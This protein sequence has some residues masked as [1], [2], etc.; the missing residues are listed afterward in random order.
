M[1]ANS[2][3]HLAGWLL[4]G[5][6]ATG[7]YS[8]TPGLPFTEDF[9]AANLRDN[10]LTSAHWNTVQEKL[11]LDA[12]KRQVSPFRG[13]TGQDLSTGTENNRSIVLG[14][15]D[16]DGDL[17]VVAGNYND[18]NRVYLNDGSGSFTVQDLSTDSNSTTSIVIGDLDRDG[19]LDV[20]AGNE[21]QINRIYLNDGAGS[22]TGQDLSTDTHDTQSLALGDMDGDGDL[23]LMEGN[24]GTSHKAN[25]WFR[26]DGAGNF[27]GGI[28][29][30]TIT[31]HSTRSI[32]LGD[33]DGDGDLDMITGNY[34][35]NN[36]LH[37]NSGNGS[38][39]AVLDL[40]PD[41]L[42]T[43][44]V[45]LG[46]IDNDGDLDLVTGN[47]G[48]RNR[49]YSND[50]SGNFTGYNIS[51]DSYQ[52]RSVT[53]A[54]IDED[55][56]LD[57]VAGNSNQ[58]NR[59]YLN[60]GG[61]FAGE[62]QSL[63]SSPTESVVV[64]DVDGDGHPDIIAGNNNQKIRLYLNNATTGFHAQDLSTDAMNSRTV[65]LGDLDGDSDLDIVVGNSNQTNRIYFNEGN[66][67]FSSQDLSPNTRSTFSIAL[68]DLD[69]DGSL[70]MV[71]GNTSLQKNFVYLNDGTGTFIS[72]ELSATLQSSRAIV[73]GDVDSDGDLDVVSGNHGSSN[74]LFLNNGDGS[75]SDPNVQIGGA[76]N[77][78]ALQLGDIDG[79]GDL[80][81]IAGNLGQVNI[82]YTN[83][84]NGNFSGQD[85]GAE[86]NDTRSIVLGDVDGDGDLDLVVGNANGQNNRLYLND[87]SGGFT[88]QNLGTGLNSTFSVA[89]G[90]VDND[91]DIDVTAAN[92]GGDMDRIYLNDG[93]GG[94]AGQDLGPDILS[95]R[96]VALGD[97]DADGDLDLVMVNDAELDRIYLN[98]NS[99]GFSSQPMNPAAMDTTSIT[100]GDLDADGD[101]DMVAAVLGGMNQIYRNDAGIF[102]RH[103]LHSNVFL[104]RSVA[105][106]DLD[107]DS[108]LDVVVGNDTEANYLYWNDGNGNYSSQV[109]TPTQHATRSIALGDL[110]GD[111]DLD[112]ATAN[113][114]QRNQLYLNDGGG[115]FSL[116]GQDLSTDSNQSYSVVLGDMNNDGHLDVVVGN[117]G[118]NRVYINDGSAGFTG[119]DLGTQTNATFSVRL[120]D[121]DQDGD[122][123][124]VT[125]NNSSPNMVHIN[126]GAGSFSSSALD[127]YTDITVSITLGDVD[128]DGDLDII[129]GN[130][131]EVNR[132]FL[133]DGTGSFTGQDLGTPA[134]DTRS[135][136]L[137]DMDRDGS[138]DLVT[139]NFGQEN[140]LYL[141]RRFSTVLNQAGSLR[142]DTET[143]NI[144]Q[145]LLSSSQLTPAN[146][147]VRYYLSNNGGSQWFLA[148]PGMPLLFPTAG[149]DLRWRAELHSLSPVHSPEVQELALAL[150]ALPH[151]SIG[152]T[153]SGLAAGNSVVL[154]NNGGDDLALGADAAF[155]FD[156]PLTDG[157]TY[158][159]TVLTQ[160]AGSQ[161][162]NVNNGNGT[163]SGADVT[164]ISITCVTTCF[165]DSHEPDDASG[166][167]TTIL[168]G[169]EQ[170]HSICPADDEDW[171][172]F[173]VAE[174]SKVIIGTS[175]SSTDP[176]TEMWLYDEALIELEYNDT[177]NGVDDWALIDR[178]CGVDALPAGTYYARIRDY[179]GNDEIPSYALN[180]STSACTGSAYYLLGGNVSGLVTGNNV[181][182]QNNGGDDLNITVNGAFTFTTPLADGSIYNASILSQPSHPDQTC[183]V[184]NGSGAISGADIS[185][186]AVTCVTD[187]LFD[188]VPPGY[189]AYDFIQT[190]AVSG[191]TSGCD[192]HNYCPSSAVSRAQMAVF[193]GRGIHGRYYIPPSATGT[194]FDDVPA[195]HWAAGWIEQLSADG[196]TGGC[197]AGNYCPEN[198]VSRDQMAV[199]L[200]RSKHGSA[201]IP[202]PASGTIFADVPASHWASAWIE[203]LASEGIS[204][205]CD[206]GNYCPGAAVQRDQ[207]A[208]FLVRTFAL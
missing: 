170:T 138:L 43:T 21:S 132:L 87:G 56:D 97:L 45:A 74:R 187:P 19:D 75:F 136:V 163:V 38:F 137:I 80:D 111:G 81:L 11:V 148:R 156:T 82:V 32:A 135:V 189:W 98:D 164:D 125:A 206:A 110:D 76:N 161:I 117:Y 154:Q 146:T 149:S 150:V 171:V 55:G 104:T 68:G 203:Q 61:S 177:S 115:V 195:S 41:T 15:L 64:G 62:A 29:L 92:L 13:T 123:D 200:L 46:D 207:M 165:A 65:A 119:H 188:D 184:S 124:V 59:I 101:L 47:Y 143:G 14:D 142:V 191:I 24:G 201:Y 157:S 4:P 129:T 89:L 85:L 178:I 180:L 152:G 67:S 57:M 167:A 197:D 77:T 106:G 127:V 169:S 50:G 205:G 26:N 122:L 3:F 17:D 94:F 70:D 9:T 103:D 44:S 27:T 168:P 173:T 108:D 118:V 190:L 6:M 113:N 183:T 158:A 42:Q 40:S 31:T 12:W 151:Y 120:G 134:F 20:V 33:V 198:T 112:I 90:D 107:N 95:S 193:L 91:G 153:V 130:S 18:N 51:N 72:H 23:D 105:L 84:G 5:L 139:G 192:L 2:V 30:G 116:L 48:E 202:P 182:L 83:D 36:Q 71:T 52:T 37:V 73:L 109:L 162:C 121:L 86:S 28:S 174:E 172:K 141:R 49:V 196:I 16:G 147:G 144:D 35:D 10:T 7:S 102:T 199:F 179:G 208:V 96:A 181:I 185:N 34:G 22:F 53:L 99:H 66:N 204:N 93:S 128:H 176:D 194:V 25:F 8:A 155:S 160:P 126:N 114:S 60:N 145:V 63:I 186:I 131:Q 79:D 78:S 39:S 175:G 58:Q 159:V 100:V 54:D 140:Q 133:N 88:G 1:A 166:A 69:G